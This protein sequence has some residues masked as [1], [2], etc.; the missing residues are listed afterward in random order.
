MSLYALALDLS[1]IDGPLRLLDGG[2]PD[3]EEML[4]I[5]RNAVE[6]VL[7]AAAP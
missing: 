3:R 2:Y 7:L 5:A 1:L 4:A 6:R